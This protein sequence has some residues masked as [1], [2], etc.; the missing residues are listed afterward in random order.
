MQTTPQC[1]DA[2]FEE[3]DNDQVRPT[4]LKDWLSAGTTKMSYEYFSR[5]QD[6]RTMYAAK[7]TRMLWSSVQGASEGD[8]RLW[9]PLD[10]RSTIPSTRECFKNTRE[11]RREKSVEASILD[12]PIYTCT[13]VGRVAS[14]PT[15]WVHLLKRQCTFHVVFLFILW[16]G[17]GCMTHTHTQR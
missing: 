1:L 17:L 4:I 2:V 10:N 5:N 8:A 3:C 9:G 7:F 6:Y 15:P 16:W 14:S 12:C 11:R 13:I